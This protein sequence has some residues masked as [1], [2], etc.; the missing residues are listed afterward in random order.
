MGGEA[1]STTCS[2]K[3][4]SA[5]GVHSKLEIS[6]VEET[7][8][9]PN[10]TSTT[11]DIGVERKKQEL[12]TSKDPIKMMRKDL[13]SLSYRDKKE[14]KEEL[15]APTLIQSTPK[16]LKKQLDTSELMSR[17]KRRKDTPTSKDKQKLK[18][19]HKHKMKHDKDLKDLFSATATIRKETVKREDKKELKEDLRKKD[20]EQNKDKKR[21]LSSNSEQDESI[22]PKSKHAK[23][24]KEVDDAES[25]KQKLSAMGRI[26][27]LDKPEMKKEEKKEKEKH[28]YSQSSS[29]SSK[30][31]S[32]PDDK[33][34]DKHRHKD[35]KDSRSKLTSVSA[36]EDKDKQAR[37]D[38]DAKKHKDK[39]EF[40]KKDDKDRQE[41]KEHDKDRKEKEHKSRD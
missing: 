23:V 39:K 2:P 36:D 37:K 22:E 41:R 28:K 24:T 16:L 5:P 27:K 10:V 6:T 14:I 15:F 4:D 20:D 35:K 25:R 19:K 12:L 34:G 9:D 1:S 32:K 38:K 30:S 3:L 11:K 17:D 33:T 18:D 29:T 31:K 21:R 40:K 13:D 7:D 8:S 26:P